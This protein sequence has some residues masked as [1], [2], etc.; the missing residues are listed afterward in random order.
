MTHDTD[1][2]P[3]RN[4][5]GRTW[6]ITWNDYPENYAEIITDGSDKCVFQL[7]I[8]D[9]GNEHVQG[10]LYFNNARSFNSVKKL[11]PGAHIE[12][13]KNWNAAVNYC[14]KSETSVAGSQVDTTQL[15]ICRDAF[16]EL[17]LSYKWW[18]QEILDI[19]DTDPC[20]TR[21]IH[22]Y[23]DAVG[24]CGKS[25]FTKHLCL[26]YG[27]IILSGKAADMQ[28]AIY[29]MKVKPKI[30]IIDIPR[31]A[32]GFV[33]Y[34]GIEKIKD[35]CFFNAKYESGMCLFDNPH[36]IC[37]ANFEPKKETMSEDRWK[38]TDINYIGLL[39]GDDDAQAYDNIELDDDL[40]DEL[41]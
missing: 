16:E 30:I 41:W 14:K 15:P 25:T 20:F 12:P 5:R 23:W 38:I 2:T 33:S 19:I 11:L 21:S 31:T 34:G 1:D 27:A 26:K 9:A 4:T 39:E 35:G 40:D 29:S 8:G 32:E 28:Y 3:G 10:A 24:G 37:F 36:I 7:E 6:F 17:E 18:Q 13:V 22:W